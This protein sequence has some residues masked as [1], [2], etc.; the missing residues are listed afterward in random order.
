MLINGYAESRISALDRG[1]Q[2]GD[3]LF[4]TIA[5]AAGDPCLWQRHIRRLESGCGRLNID[6]P[7]ADA[8]LE[9]VYREIGG[10]S[11]GVIKIILTRGIGGRGYRPPVNETPTRL[12]WFLDWPE[13]PARNFHAG[14]RVRLC[15][16]RLCRNPRLAGL[17][18]LNRLE[19]VLARSEWLDPDISEGLMQDSEGFIVEGTM[20]NLFFVHGE[21]VTTPDLGS[22]GVAGVMR[23]VVME[24]ADRLGLPLSI[25]QLK[26]PDLKSADGIFLSNSLIGIWPV[27]EVDGEKID[28]AAVPASLLAAVME[29][30]FR[31]G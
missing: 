4:E 17:K 13:Y 6:F 29:N 22:A 25:E 11:R 7:D 5:V 28:P 26:L 23:E 8:L 1:L 21:R 12:V 20:S 30:G 27:R 2:Y 19:Q 15:D 16:I 24:Q 9:E 14:V 3:G 31:F 18:T 10:R